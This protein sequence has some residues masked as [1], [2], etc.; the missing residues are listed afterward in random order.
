MS[1]SKN[2]KKTTASKKATARKGDDPAGG[3]QHLSPVAIV[4]MGALF[5]GADGVGAFWANIKA[6]AARSDPSLAPLV[7]RVT[8]TVPNYFRFVNQ[9]FTSTLEAQLSYQL[10]AADYETAKDE[11]WNTFMTV[12]SD[13]LDSLARLAVSQQQ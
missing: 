12:L 2:T 1:R 13:R 9:D 6:L 10:L 3:K 5:P 7:D 4:G 8:R 11:F